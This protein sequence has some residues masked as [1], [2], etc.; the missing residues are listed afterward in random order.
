MGE[1]NYIVLGIRLSGPK[2]HVVT[3]S[4][5]TNK[6][7]LQNDMIVNYPSLGIGAVCIAVCLILTLYNMVMTMKR[8]K[9][10]KKKKLKL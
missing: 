4:V 6:L 7:A 5:P 1:N 2:N 10:I 9:L 8:V 3:F